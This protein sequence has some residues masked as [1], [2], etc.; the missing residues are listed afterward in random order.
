MVLPSV[1]TES[2]ASFSLVDRADTKEALPQPLAVRRDRKTSSPAKLSGRTC[3]QKYSFLL[4]AEMTGTYSEPT[5]ELAAVTAWAFM[6]L[7]HGA[8]IKASKPVI[9][10]GREAHNG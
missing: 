5:T 3:A 2:G 8:S 9:G 10:C 6:V 7:S 4:S 1:L